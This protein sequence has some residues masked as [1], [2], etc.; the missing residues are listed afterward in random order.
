LSALAT[1]K[2]LR[3]RLGSAGKSHAD[4]YFSLD[5]MLRDHTEIYN[6]SDKK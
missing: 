5:R 2:E 6:R 3:E 1:D 4:E